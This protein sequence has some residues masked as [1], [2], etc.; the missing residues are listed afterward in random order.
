MGPSHED[1]ASAATSLAEHQKPE[2]PE[3]HQQQ[4]DNNP[5]DL[6][7]LDPQ[8]CLKKKGRCD[9]FKETSELK[10]F[11]ITVSKNKRKI[12]RNWCYVDK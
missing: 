2:P 9:G 7:N 4:K 8:T 10:S 1:E 12:R 11:F 5:T 6:E 3:K